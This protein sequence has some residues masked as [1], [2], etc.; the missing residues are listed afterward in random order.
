MSPNLS[1]QKCLLMEVELRYGKA[2]ETPYDFV[3]LRESIQRETGEY[4]SVS[5]LKRL[6]GYVKNSGGVR[7]STLDV[8]ARYVE[9][10][11]FNDFIC[12]MDASKY[13]DSVYFAGA[14]VRSSDLSSGDNVILEWNPDR[15]VM[16]VYLGDNV[17]EVTDS[18]TSKLNAGDHFTA[19]AFIQGEP[20]YLAEV[21]RH[22]SPVSAY[23]AGRRGGLT[24]VEIVSSTP[25]HMRCKSLYRS[26]IRQL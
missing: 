7:P 10:Y 11:N 14:V 2:V 26:M 6:W 1:E 19:C 22:G 4:I 3:C 24:R 23:I 5:T 18:G 8:L 16:L 20:L 25:P 17:F 9:S 15:R 13:Q 21:I 12:C